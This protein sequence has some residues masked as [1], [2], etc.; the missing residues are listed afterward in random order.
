M[1]SAQEETSFELA[2][3]NDVV[4]HNSSFTVAS[5]SAGWSCEKLRAGIGIETCMFSTSWQQPKGLTAEPSS[6]SV[7]MTC[8]NGIAQGQ[9]CESTPEKI[10]E[11]PGS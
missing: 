1:G 9:I 11:E 7:E 4:V 3:F 8:G 2:M 6:I 10:D 5:L